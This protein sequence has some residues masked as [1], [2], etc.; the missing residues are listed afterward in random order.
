ML[1][2]GIGVYKGQFVGGSLEGKGRFEYHD[3]S[4][5]EGW[6]KEDKKHGFGRMTE[7]DGV[8]FYNGEWKNDFKNGRGVMV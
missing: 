3:G 7:P 6:M 5:Y 4:V 1:F 8:S 2:V